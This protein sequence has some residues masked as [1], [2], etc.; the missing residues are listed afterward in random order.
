MLAVMIASSMAGA[1]TAGLQ[2]AQ[3]DTLIAKLD[4]LIT[5]LDGG[6]ADAPG[7]NVVAELGSINTMLGG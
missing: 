7:P 6:G 1:A 2:A 5:S 3:I 4:R